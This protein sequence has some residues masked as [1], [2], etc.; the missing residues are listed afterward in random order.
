MNVFRG[1]LIR[2]WIKGSVWLILSFEGGV[3]LWLIVK[4]LINEYE[5]IELIEVNIW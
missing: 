4:L 3:Y 5:C 1:V 2:V